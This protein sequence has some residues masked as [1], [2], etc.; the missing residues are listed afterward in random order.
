MT[1]LT[2]NLDITDPD[3]LTHSAESIALLHGL[4]GAEVGSLASD[5]PLWFYPTPPYWLV[6]GCLARAILY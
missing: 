3:Q 2:K 5:R 4:G 1:D 6:Y